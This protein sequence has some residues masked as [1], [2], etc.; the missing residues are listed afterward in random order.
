V[1]AVMAAS[2][3]LAAALEP[4]VASVLGGIAVVAVVWTAG[5]GGRLAARIRD[6]FDRNARAIGL[7]PCDRRTER[8]T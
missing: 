8:P 6:A 2:V 3:G 1:L 5:R 4:G 7:I